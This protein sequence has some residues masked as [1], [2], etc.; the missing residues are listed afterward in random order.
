[1]SM[2]T[3][4]KTSTVTVASVAYS[5]EHGTRLLC[6]KLTG[7]EDRRSRGIQACAAVL[8]KSDD[9][10]VEMKSLQEN[11]LA[12]LEVSSFTY[13]AIVF[14]ELERRDHVTRKGWQNKLPFRLTLKQG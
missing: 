11:G 3:L 13:A 6:V 4:S 14:R 8:V 9:L 5:K 10:N 2:K 12:V 7:S 1:M